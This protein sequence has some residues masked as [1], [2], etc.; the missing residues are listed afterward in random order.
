MDKPIQNQ[1]DELALSI[2]A[3]LWG[4]T[5]S[6][7]GAGVIVRKTKYVSQGQV[8]PFVIVTPHSGQ[9]SWILT[10]LRDIGSQYEN[11]YIWKETFFQ[12]LALAGSKVPTD[13]SV[14]ILLFTCLR[15]AYQ[16]FAE[17][18]LILATEAWIPVFKLAE[19]LKEDESRYTKDSIIKFF[20]KRG[21]AV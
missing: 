19:L 16:I 18:D 9:L 7:A 12:R 1:L 10:R 14:D 20:S 21:I 17:N 11:F 5:R 4:K 6:W 3:Q 13:E 15:E 8:E 2:S